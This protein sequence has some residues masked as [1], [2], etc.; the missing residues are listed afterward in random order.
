MG[1][2]EFAVPSLQLLFESGYAP[3]C[4]VTGPDRRMG[5]GRRTGVSAVKSAAT[6]LGIDHIVQPESVRD[7]GFASEIAA[8][9]PDVIAVVAYRIL[10]PSVFT[11]AR[12]GAFNL[13]ASLLPR[14]RG[15][16]PIH[17]AIINGESE[18]GVTTF[19]LKERV[20]TGNMILQK[21]I[22]I[23]PD[24]TTGELYDRMKVLGAA[25]VVD[26]VR[27][28]E[29]GE[30]EEV[31]QDERF[32]SAAPKVFADDGCVVWDRPARQVHD[33]IRGFSPLP[34]AWTM[35]GETR[36][37]LLRSKMADGAGVPGEV[38]EA[39][40]RLVIA[41]SDGAVEITEAQKQGRN[42]MSATELLRGYPLRAGDSLSCPPLG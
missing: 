9:E 39:G 32:A 37:K 23:G 6:A 18:S 5:R 38:L 24:E 8:L 2:P 21:P 27:L 33:F 19:F 41:C 11:V 10:P 20:D 1:T 34:G 26:T 36:L 17:H 14:Y 25:A 40:P 7:P 42:A 13:H 30:V 16:A 3:V 22:P 31:V 4:V 15:P 35:H 12:H 28:I 29:A